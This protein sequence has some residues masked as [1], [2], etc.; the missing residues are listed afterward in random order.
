MTRRTF[1]GSVVALFAICLANSWPVTARADVKLPKVFGNHMVLQQK[2]NAA[3]WGWAEANE[4]IS[5]SL[6]GTQVTTKAG[7]DGKWSTKVATPAAG[8]PHELV[9]KGKNEIKLTDV[10][11]GEVWICSGQSNME[12]TV[13]QSLNPQEEAK[14]ATFPQIRMIKVAHNPAEKPVDDINGQWQVCA[15]ETASAFSAVGYFFARHLQKELNVPIGMINTSWGGTICEAWT[16]HGALAAD[17]DFKPMLDRANP[18]KPGN[19]NQASALYNG[20]VHPLVPFTIRGAIWYQGESNCSRAEQYRKLFPA[21]ITDWR[22]QFAQG[23]FPFLFVQL[24]PF[25]YGHHPELLAELWEAQTKTLKVTNTGMAVTTDISTINDIHPPNKQDVGKRLALWALAKHYGKEG[26]VHSGPLY[27]SMA[28]EGNKVRIKFQHVGGGLTTRD[29]KA[30]THFTIAGADLKF[31]PA[32]AAIDG[33][34]I[35]V[36]SDQVAAP[37]AVRFAWDQVAEPNLGNKEGLPASPFR[38]DEG[39]LISA[40]AK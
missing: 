23:D 35:V 4:E 40:G 38:T 24:A 8:G 33:N 14:N 1:F 5:V 12:W 27:E 31:V 37:T 32:T 34:S 39:K 36:T 30:P 21:M 13:A 9:V 3:I 7:A 20:M 15:P 6:A 18:F 19:P 16:S 25:K 29:G 26:L 2:S 28:V 11:S 22:K 17:P 10:Y